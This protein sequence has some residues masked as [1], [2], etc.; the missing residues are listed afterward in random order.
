[1]TS[2]GVVAGAVLL[3]ALGALGAYAL[4]LYNAL[5]TLRN[6]V[7]RAWANVDV[8]LKQRSDEL[9]NLVAI[10]KG[11]AAH[12]KALFEHVAAARSRLASAAGAHEKAG[13]SEALTEDFRRI[14]AIAEAYPDLKANENFLALQKRLSAIEDVLADR[15]EFYN[16][17]VATWNTRIQEVPEV[18]LAKRLRFA[19]REYFKAEGADREAVRLNAG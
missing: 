9:P 13:P 7:E 6:N 17:S 10:V 15:R 14:V 12:E 19:P 1:M 16:E 8:I 2:A 18:I 3:A 11:Y 5:V 4:M